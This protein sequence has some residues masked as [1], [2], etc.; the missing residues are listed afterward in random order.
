MNTHSVYA[1]CD[2]RTGDIRYIGQAVDIHQRYA[3][4]LLNKEENRAKVAWLS[5][6]KAIGKIPTLIILEKDIEKR[7]ILHREM[8]WIGHYLLCGANLLNIVI[9]G[10]APIRKTKPTV[11]APT[12]KAPEK[13]KKPAP[14]PVPKPVYP[15]GTKV[16][17]LADLARRFSLKERV[18]ERCILRGEMKA[19]HTEQ[20]WVVTNTDLNKWV[21]DRR[22]EAAREIEER[23]RHRE[24]RQ[25]SV[26]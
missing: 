15:E 21:D 4:H 22:E 5:E 6:L 24:N 12:I 23:H 10:R 9:P 7:D 13:I 26:S 18:F 20:G 17:T 11:K 25:Q 2:P 8:H 16:Y 3:Q 19:T 1:L 14:T